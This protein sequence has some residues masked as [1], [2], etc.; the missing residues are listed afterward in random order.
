[1]MK[2]IY[3]KLLGQ[4]LK[5][6]R[7]NP[8]KVLD[9]REKLWYNKIRKEGIRMKEFFRNDHLKIG[10]TRR[11]RALSPLWFGIRIVQALGFIL[12]SYVFIVSLWVLMG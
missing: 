2:G 1:M 5:A 10:K 6:P 8:K 7:E 12:V 11:I 9:K 3:W 4:L